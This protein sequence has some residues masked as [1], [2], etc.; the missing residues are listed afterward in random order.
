[1]ADD[2]FEIWGK[3][4]DL[5]IENMQDGKSV[6]CRAPMAAVRDALE[7]LHIPQ[8]DKKARVRVRKD[9]RQDFNE[10]LQSRMI[11]AGGGNAPTTY[12]DVFDVLDALVDVLVVH[13]YD[14]ED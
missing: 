1:M 3:N 2:Y 10:L 13:L 9:I 12:N 4:G 6:V 14:K 8:R 7:S 11:P 5:C